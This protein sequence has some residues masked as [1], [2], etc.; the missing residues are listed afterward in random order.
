M[1]GRQLIASVLALL[2]CMAAPAAHAADPPDGRELMAAQRQAME[3]LA[4]LDGTWRGPATVWLPGGQRR[5][6]VQTE[7][8]GS[9]LGGAV[10]MIE[11]RGHGADGALEFNALAVVSFSPQA[12]Q[13]RMRSYAQGYSG[14]FAF[15][16][17]PGGFVWSIPA[18]PATLSIRTGAPILPTGVYFTPRYN[19]HHA[20][21][22]PPVPTHRLGPGLRDDVA[23]VTQSLAHELEFLIR[24]A[25]EQWHMVQP[26]WPSDPGY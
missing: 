6:L 23:R 22:R 11:G 18:G 15:E 3:P 14:D 1:S 24:R 13:Y 12:G 2:V 16:L 19:G 7:R 9:F 8:V 17:L 5:E 21:V 10:K 4:F 20:I 26:N 25:P